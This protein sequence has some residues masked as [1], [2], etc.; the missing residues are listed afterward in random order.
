MEK[1]VGR[2]RVVWSRIV[3]DIKNY[4]I[5][6]ML[7]AVYNVV[8]RNLFH[9]FC[10]FLIAV[11]FPCAGC[12]MT[13]AIYHILTGS[14]QRGM[15]LNPAAPFWILFFLYFFREHYIK[16]RNGK[17][18]LWCLGVVCAVTFLIYIYRMLHE[19]PGA[20]PLVYYRN[21]LVVRFLRWIRR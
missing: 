12:G 19:F 11:G 14:F 2:C 20:P 21:N 15:N 6:I 18:L 7:F 16:G 4:Y 17:R 5:A 13:R 3:A 1:I 9:A 10:P 8:I